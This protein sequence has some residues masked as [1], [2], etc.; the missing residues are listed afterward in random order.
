MALPAVMTGRKRFVARAA[1]TSAAAEPVGAL[2]GLAGVSAFPSLNATFLAFAAGAM[3][4][5]SLHELLPMARR[6]GHHRE[7]ALG[8]AVGA[9]TLGVLELLVAP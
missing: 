5:V 9:T 2:V 6:F 3:V 7:S 4:Y 1:I 8:I